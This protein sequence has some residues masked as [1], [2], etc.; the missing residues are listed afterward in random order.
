MNLGICLYESVEMWT[1]TS[2]SVIWLVVPITNTYYIL[3]VWRDIND[4]FSNAKVQLQLFATHAS[5]RVPEA[6]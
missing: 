4:E 2:A 3:Q 1:Q 6:V 5:Y